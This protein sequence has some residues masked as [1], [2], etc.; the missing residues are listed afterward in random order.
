MAGTLTELHL[1]IRRE[2]ELFYIGKPFDK[3]RT[4]RAVSREQFK[5]FN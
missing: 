1:F 3:L 5:R 4:L 2:L